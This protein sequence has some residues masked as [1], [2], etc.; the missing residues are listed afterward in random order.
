MQDGAVRHRR[1]AIHAVFA[2]NGV[3]LAG[4]AS[5][6][7]T[8]RDDLDLTVVELG[9][10]L[11]TLSSASVVGLALSGRIV[12]SLG[13]RTT[14]VSGLVLAATGLSAVGVGA[15]LAHD[16]R[17]AGAG[18]IAFGLGSGICNVAMNVA[19]ASLESL[20]SRPMMPHFHAAFSVGSV[21]G[22]GVA[23]A[24]AAAGL[25]VV[26]DLAGIAV[27]LLVVA[28]VTARHLE[29]AA[30][31]DRSHPE[32]AAPTPG[33]SAWLERRTL[34]IGLLVMST[35]FAAG[36]AGDWLSVAMVDGHGGSDALGAIAYG[37]FSV[38]VL[39]GRLAGTV[40]LTRFGRV[41][42]LRC[43]AALVGAGVILV[44]VAP[45][46]VAALAGAALWGLGAALGYPV[47]MS[48][49]ADDAAR[50]SARISVVA[51]IGYT[52]SL[53][54]PPL[55]GLLG[56]GLGVLHALAGVLVFALLAGV[57][58]GSARSERD[59]AVSASTG[60]PLR[61]SRRGGS[62]G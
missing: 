6:L 40:V 45:H 44:I 18:L 53:I 43:C 11:L 33:R 21:L 38:A 9:L 10:L 28:T 26:A 14:I 29:T 15:S 27:L 39:A 3:A 55:I 30:V 61:G 7:P 32:R 20:R 13:P 5:R 8:L 52:A 50:A 19:G 58:A 12:G 47:G 22:A 35:V 23:A 62:P 41:V 31:R 54:E 4:L 57:L 2:V 25:P 37:V 46:A 36:A 17:A 48:A 60:R 1:D 51:T 56:A 49:A 59:A 42:V 16:P 34:M 24:C